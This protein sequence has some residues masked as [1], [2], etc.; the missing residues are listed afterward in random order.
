M[1]TKNL[2][3]FSVRNRAIHPRFLDTKNRH[4]QTL[5]EALITLYASGSGQSL[6]ALAELA[7]PILN[8]AHLPLAAKGLNKLVLDQCTFEEPD[9]EL[10]SFRMDVFTVAAQRFRQSDTYPLPSSA[11]SVSSVSSTNNL[12]TFRQG[13]AASLGMEPD[14]LSSRL[15][16]DLPHRQILLSLK[17]LSPEQL[18]HR[19]N[20]A[21]AQGPLFWANQLFIEMKEPDVGIRRKF[22]HRLKF[23]RL[24]ARISQK[25]SG[26][27]EIQLDG[28]LTLFDN[29]R[30]YGFQ[31]ASFLPSVCALSRWRIQADLRMDN[32]ELVTLTLD[33]DTGL[34][35]HFGQTS[36][37]V[38]EEFERFAVQ[39]NEMRGAGQKA[40]GWKLKKTPTLLNLGGQEWIVPDFSFRHDSGQV[41]H[42]ELFHRWHAGP[43]HRRLEGLQKRE[44]PVALGV[45]RFL[46]KDEQTHEML[47]HSTWYQRHGFPFNSFPPVKR[48]VACLNGFLEPVSP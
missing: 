2:L 37:Y 35:S 45:D 23:F 16:A 38:P 33:Q 14:A 6:E 19:Y 36:T 41:V 13:V 25:R 10:E 3:R 7:Q 11:S 40:E 18:L 44:K 28:P 26:Q 15:H 30:K 17:P 29:H 20:M 39:F 31:L 42:L 24:L 46:T 8:T 22:F 9:T 1:L 27:F 5:A 48:V 12:E 21:Q 32:G 43:L 4:W 34:K 47:Q